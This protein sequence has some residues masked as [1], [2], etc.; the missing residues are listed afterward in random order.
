MENAA[1]SLLDRAY[2][3]IK[4]IIIS[5]EFL[6]GSLV[7]ENELSK[8]LGISRTPVHAA[9]AKLEQEGFVELISKR[10]ALVKDV[11]FSEFF[12]MHE[13]IVALERYAL[14][15]A[16]ARGTVFAL[17][18]LRSCLDRQAAALEENDY[19]SYYAGGFDFASMI[20]ETLN[21]KKMLDVVDLFR[22]RMMFK[23]IAYRK[24]HPG[25]KPHVALRTHTSMH[26]ALAAGNISEAAAELMRNLSA[27]SKYLMENRLI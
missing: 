12:E 17:D 3:E 4:R 22:G 18:R 25:T 23:I 21:N 6:P 26:R 24:T 2:V 15:R 9:M 16:K 5:A 14:S 27:I 11:S 20:I 8:R 7:S 1:E 13:T 10:G 19:L